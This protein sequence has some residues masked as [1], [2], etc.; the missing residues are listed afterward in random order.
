[1]SPPLL[2]ISGYHVHWVVIGAETPNW[3]I[4]PPSKPDSLGRL[5]LWSCV[6]LSAF[7]TSVSH[8]QAWSATAGGA[9]TPASAKMVLLYQSRVISAA[10]GVPQ[11]CLSPYQKKFSG[12]RSDSCGYFLM[13]L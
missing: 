12:L 1:M 4:L 6:S 10:P 2:R 8:D 5:P 3:R 9:S 11:T 13:Y 7:S